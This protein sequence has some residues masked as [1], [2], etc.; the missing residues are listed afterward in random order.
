VRAAAAGSARV[1]VEPV[2]PADIIGLY[3]L[4]PLVP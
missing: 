2:V 3:V 1:R 4:A